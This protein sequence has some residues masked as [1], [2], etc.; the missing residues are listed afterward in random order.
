MEAAQPTSRPPAKRIAVGD[1]IDEVFSIYRQNLGALL[2]SAIVVFVVVGFLAG[3]LQAGGGLILVLL[4]GAVRFAGQALYTGFVV[5]LVEDVRDGRRDHGVG[6]LFSAASPFIL[7]LIGFGILFGLG[8]SIG[9]FLLIV[10]G[11]VL[12]TFWSLGAPAIVVEGIGPIDAFRRSWQL[13]RG[14]AWAVFGT[15]LVVLLITIGIWIVLA[16]IATPIG[17]GE[18]ATWIASI[19]S[20]TLTAPIFALTVT[21]L[22]YE[23]AGGAAPATAVPTAPPTSEAPPPPPPPPVG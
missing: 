1:V 8:V 22:Y 18:V 6:D 2:G 16:L 20:G 17:D 21:V 10:P 7:P 23:L 15:L 14:N 9:F 4:A 11:L 3:I 13:V 12:I 5:K 19:V